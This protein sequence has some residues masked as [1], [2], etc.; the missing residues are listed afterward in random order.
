MTSGIR[1]LHYV[2]RIVNREKAVKFYTQ[3][4]GMK[5]L[6]HEEFVEPCGAKCNGPYDSMWSKTMV[7]YGT[8]D[9]HFVL[10]LTYNYGITSYKGGNDLDGIYIESDEIYN[11]VDG[12]GRKLNDAC[13]HLKDPDGH[14]FFISKGASQ[15]P[16]AM[17]SINT[18]DLVKSE[19]FW[20]KL[21]RMEIV[22][23]MADKCLLSCGRNQCKLQIKSLPVGQSLDRGS[24]FGRIAYSAPTKLLKVIE[25]EVRLVDAKYILTP[26]KRL[27]T[28]GKATVSVVILQDPNNHEI[29]FVGDEA[30]RELSVYDSNAD[31]ML[32]EAMEKDKS[33]EGQ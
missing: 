20:T 13:I 33:G 9:E 19:D 3:F 14:S 7:G 12:L 1:A 25:D 11:K 21:C 32:N 27:D 24:A 23:S 30:F 5:V 15:F 26:L 4:L 10:E 31:A 6:R 17:V 8:E 22:E 28:P 16:I 2:F 29:C 18:T